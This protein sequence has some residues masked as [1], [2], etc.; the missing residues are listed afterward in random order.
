MFI[1][2]KTSLLFKAILTSTTLIKKST[3]YS[4]VRNWLN[5][6]LLLSSG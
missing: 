5:D 2:N 3:E 1:K 6:G 4:K